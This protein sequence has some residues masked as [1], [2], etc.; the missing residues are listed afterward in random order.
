MRPVSFSSTQQRKVYTHMQ[1]SIKPGLN[2]SPLE[3]KKALTR[4][5]PTNITTCKL[6]KRS[7]FCR[8]SF[9]YPS[10]RLSREIAYRDLGPLVILLL[11]PRFQKMKGKRTTNGPVVVD[12]HVNTFS[13]RV[14][15]CFNAVQLVDLL[16]IHH[17]RLFKD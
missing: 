4:L 13:S 5:H 7:V 16:R 15:S 11:K 1:K 10:S 14:R 3:P 8:P 9:L 2:G 17:V 6:G 12:N